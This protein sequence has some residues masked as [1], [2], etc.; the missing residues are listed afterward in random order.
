MFFYLKINFVWPQLRYGTV[1]IIIVLI[2]MWN[3]INFLSVK[4]FYPEPNLKTWHGP[5]H[6]IYG[7]FS[8]K[9][10]M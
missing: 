1:T 9:R 10:L 5:V 2:I 4:K 8:G 6:Y 3:N 7:L